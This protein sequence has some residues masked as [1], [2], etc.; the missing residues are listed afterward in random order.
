[1]LSCALWGLS[2]PAMRALHI[3]Q[4]GRM[5]DSTTAFLSAWLQV[6]RFGTAAL[7]LLPF[8]LGK[9]RPT[10]LELRQGVMLALW[11]GLGM[12]LQADGLAHTDASIS[13]FL[14]QAYCVFLPLWA[15]LVQRRRPS[16][17][18]IAATLLV[19]AGGAIL[20]GVRLDTFRIGR[21]EAETILA[22]FLF[23]FQILTLESPR[24][25]GN[26]ALPVTVVM[27]AAIT[28][29]FV[30]ISLALAGSPADIL[31]AGASP[32]AAAM[33]LL[34][35][36]ACSV[37]A[38]LL[39]NHWQPHVKATEA[40]LIYT[41]EPVITSVYVLFLPAWLGAIAH[42]S[43]PNESITPALWLGGGLIVAANL[44]MQLRRPVQAAENTG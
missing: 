26:R 4:A 33:V 24:Y 27:F 44:L 39:M 32:A 8:V 20:S 19:L 18:L 36:V 16:S 6:A 38:Y 41:T 13:A 22:A 11:G 17:R 25:T 34:L 37:G 7:I 30:P 9:F 35:A 5:P 14:T 1:M 28:L 43:Y 10:R 23:T 31:T 15:T 3:E 40:G 42:I 12:A 29:Q 21:G 2:F